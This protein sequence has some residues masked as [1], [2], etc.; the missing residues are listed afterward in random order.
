ML[1]NRLGSGGMA[2]GPSLSSDRM[3]GETEGILPGARFWLMQADESFRH[4]VRFHVSGEF[5]QRESV[6]S[7]PVRPPSIRFL[8]S[9]NA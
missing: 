5:F 6:F 2:F 9:M 7:R 1:S 3:L 4:I 8:G